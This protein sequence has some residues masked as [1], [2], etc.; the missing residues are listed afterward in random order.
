MTTTIHINRTFL[1]LTFYFFLCVPRV[2]R[3]LFN[4]SL[5]ASSFGFISQDILPPTIGLFASL[6]PISVFEFDLFSRAYFARS[7]SG[8]FYRIEAL[9]RISPLFSSAFYTRRERFLQSNKRSKPHSI[10][11]LGNIRFCSFFFEVRMPHPRHHCPPASSFSITSNRLNSR[12][13]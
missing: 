13:R 11:V 10:N 1:C 2:H 4:S 3:V 9:S 6:S 12:R 8:G 5:H 7:L